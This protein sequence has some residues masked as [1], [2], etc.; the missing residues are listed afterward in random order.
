MGKKKD[1]HKY[2]HSYSDKLNTQDRD[3]MSES[4]FLSSVSMVVR[5]D[6]KDEQCQ[7]QEQNQDECGVRKINGF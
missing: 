7:S 3:G 2:W 6:E 4:W 5:S 1:N